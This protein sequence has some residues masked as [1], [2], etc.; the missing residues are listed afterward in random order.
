[1]DPN[2]PA[3]KA[4]GNDRLKLKCDELLSSF[5]FNVNLRRYTMGSQAGAY[6]RSR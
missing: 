5:G 3:L 1:M 4:P 6:T 2:K